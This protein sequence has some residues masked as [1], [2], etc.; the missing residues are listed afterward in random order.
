VTIVVVNV[1]SESNDRLGELLVEYS[2]LPEYSEMGTPTVN[3]KSLFGDY[4]IHI[5]ATRGMPD[6][7]TLL[8][9]NGADV[10]AKGEHGYTPLHDAVEQGHIEAVQL[11]LRHGATR[12]IRN[13][14]GDTPIE[15]AALLHEEAIRELLAAAE[16]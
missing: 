16:G 7:I 9:E 12:S 2:G 4:P 8:L 3:T 15:L 1:T 6:E 5:A 13:D 14:D 10:N 11:L